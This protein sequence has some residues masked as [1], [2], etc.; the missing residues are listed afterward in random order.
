[1]S[2]LVKMKKKVE[3]MFTKEDVYS[4]AQEYNEL[5][6]KIKELDS[7]KKFLSEKIKEG[8]EMF[9]VKDDKE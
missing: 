1:M 9:G 7:R 2:K 8:S 5:S 4:M 3:S 6:A